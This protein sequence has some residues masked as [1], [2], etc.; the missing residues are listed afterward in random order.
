MGFLDILWKGQGKSKS[1]LLTKEKKG[2][3]VVKKLAKRKR[4][5]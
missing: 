1:T 4:K 2:I 5:R 3:Y